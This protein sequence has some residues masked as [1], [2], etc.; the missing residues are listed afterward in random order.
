MSKLNLFALL[1]LI[2][3]L[4]AFLHAQEEPLLE[5]SLDDAVQ[6]ALEKNTQVKNARIDTQIA[7]KKIWEST[8][9]GLPQIDASAQYTNI[10]KVPVARFPNGDGTYSEVPLGVVD[11]T[12]FD[13]TVSQLIFSGPY[14]IGLRASKVYSQLTQKQLN[15]SEQEVKA[16]I[17][18]SYYLVL[19]S[20]INTDILSDNL[21]SMEHLLKETE[22]YQQ[23]GFGSKTDVDQL[24]VNVINVRNAKTESERNLELTY[25]MLKYQ[26][27]IPYDSQISL[28]QSIDDFL[29]QVDVESLVSMNFDISSN[30]NYQLMETQKKLSKLD[31]QLSKTEY[32][33]NIAAFYQHEEKL[34]KPDFDFSNPNMIG[35]TASIPIFSSGLRYAKMK[36]KKFSYDQAGNNLED[37][38][39]GLELQVEQARS[40]LRTSYATYLSQKENSKLADDIYD[41]IET[42]YKNGMASSLEL[43]Q[44]QNQKLTAQFD[45]YASIY[46]LL[47]R[48]INYDKLLNTL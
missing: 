14:I 37:L 43:T 42:K 44:V 41:R 15:I 7:K 9:S 26:M 40:D 16:L 38:E 35:I 5:L 8:A 2:I 27:G 18:E 23:E 13:I 32:L 10:F 6:L 12:V 3:I 30:L 11:N 21:L 19:V 47:Q 48:K 36:Q 31:W 45:Y 4:P 17:A 22:A 39:R 28:S 25:K 24:R 20:K 33:P 29:E 1:S 46:T 34:N